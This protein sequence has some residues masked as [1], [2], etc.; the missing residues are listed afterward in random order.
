MEAHMTPSLLHL[1][2]LWSCGLQCLSTRGWTFDKTCRCARRRGFSSYWMSS[3][4]TAG[5]SERFGAYDRNMQGRASHDAGERHKPWRCLQN[6]R[7]IPKGL[8]DTSDCVARLLPG[9]CLLVFQ[10]CVSVGNEHIPYTSVPGKESDNGT[11]NDHPHKEPVLS[12]S[13]TR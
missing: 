2:E 3:A 4:S 10:T 6:E 11:D 5:T 8:C 12:T 1:C 13:T 7:A 9:D